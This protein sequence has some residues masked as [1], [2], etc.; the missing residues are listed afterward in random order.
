MTDDCKHFNMRAALVNIMEKIRTVNSR[1][2]IKSSVTNH[3]W[4]EITG[5]L[6]REAFNKE[7]NAQ[8][9]QAGN[10]PS[11]IRMLI[12]IFLHLK[13]NNIKFNNT[14]YNHLQHHD[15]YLCLDCFQQNNTLSSGFVV[16]L[17]PEPVRIEDYKKEM[18]KSIENN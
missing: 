5:I 12:T 13:S 10:K 17:H 1:T 9:E 8:Q 16:D 3:I 6:A 7:F 18:E 15:I 14:M 2:Y 4:K 11:K